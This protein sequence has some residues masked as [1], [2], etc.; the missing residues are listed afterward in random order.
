[1]SGVP[2]GGTGLSRKGATVTPSAPTR[3]A[4]TRLETGRILLVGGGVLLFGVALVSWLLS[5]RVP[6]K[7]VEPSEP[8]QA[9]TA[10]EM[11]YVKEAPKPEPVPPPPEDTLTP[12]LTALLAKLQRM[13]AELDELKNRK[14]TQTTVVQK[15]PEQKPA[16]SRP[17][18]SPMLFTTHDPK[19][20]PPVNTVP[21]YTLAPGAT[22]I[23][24]LV[25]TAMNSDV[26]GYFISKVTTNVYDTVT[27]R[28]LLVPQGSSIM[29]HTQSDKLIYGSERMDTVSLTLTLSDG[30]VVDLGKAPVTDQEGVAGLVGDVDHHFWRMF[31]A[32]FIGGALKG[33]M[34]TLQ[35][36]AANAAG[37]GQ[38][39]TGITSLGNQATT[40]VIQPYINTRPTIRVFSGQ[41][42]HVLLTKAISLP[43]VWQ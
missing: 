17:P 41:G 4:A 1:V 21:L 15:M 6:T 38:V 27:G 34:T 24:C 3:R 35:I 18:A 8:S 11:H 32:V 25:E 7:P 16:P 23:P 10:S 37:A 31:R 28:H 22:K 26:P 20:A 5:Q 29:G 43:A 12:M 33:G 13:Q 14:P 19:E 40:T 30:R 42:C 39:A 9:Y 2:A 36:A